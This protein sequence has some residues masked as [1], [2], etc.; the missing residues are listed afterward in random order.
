MQDATIQIGEPEKLDAWD[1]QSWR[2]ASPA[3][4]VVCSRE[5]ADLWIGGKA[6]YLVAVFSVLLG[7]ETFVLATN[8]ELSLYSAQEM[9]FETLKS[10]LQISLL[11]GLIIGADSISGERERATL[12][13][14]LLTPAGRRE[15]MFGKFL[16]ALSAWP[17]ALL[18][19]VPFLSLLSQN[20]GT[21]GP[22]V[23]WGLLVGA[24]LIPGFTAVGMIVSLYCNSNKTSFFISLGIFLVVILMGQV[25]GTTKIGLWG[26]LLLWVNPLP[27]GFDFLSNVLVS[28]RT[29]SELWPSLES[30][31][32]FA[33]VAIGLL[34]LYAS[35]HLRAE[36][37]RN[38]R[39]N[40]FWYRI[41]H[42][43]GMAVITGLL[44]S[45]G[46]R[47]AMALPFAEAPGD[48]LQIGISTDAQI[49]K[50]GDTFP[51]D[52]VVT[53]IGT[54]TSSP[55]IVAMNIINLSQTGDVVDPED[56]SPERTQ[57]LNALA[58]NQSTKLSWEINAVL[59]GEFMVYMVA[60]PEPARVGTSTQAVASR[61]LHLSV[62][63]YTRLNPGGIL[64]YSI[65]VPMVVMVVIL[66]IFR[67]RNR[68]VDAGQTSREDT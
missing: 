54:E 42:V 43:L 46:A 59:D 62:A 56:W 67:L 61:G 65:G 45:T 32:V 63:R 1:V 16:G 11:I 47:S 39:T 23:L 50:T 34:F 41:S 66:L 5:L 24:L 51:F 68:Q 55:V 52:T 36:T 8:F 4:Q 18:I 28:N 13:D 30:P 31:F 14:L 58:P 7:I 27:A 49:L 57:Y 2:P 19:T 12:E 60:V 20:S 25:I 6:L 29:F 40:S 21:F 48:H 35:P 3:W 53:N 9:V 38:H 26:Q 37:G 64:P 15:I 44:L 17:A 10:V 33:V 22:A